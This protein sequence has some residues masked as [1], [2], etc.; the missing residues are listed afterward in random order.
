MGLNTE[1]ACQSFASRVSCRHPGVDLPGISIPVAVWPAI[2]GTLVHWGDRFGWDVI[3]QSIPLIRR[4]PQHPGCR[5]EREIDDVSQ[6]SGKLAP[7]AVNCVFPDGAPTGI[8]FDTHVAAGPEC[9]VEGPGRID[10]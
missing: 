8:G 2:V 3:A 10:R 5:I 6:P 1:V 9:D 7:G 4:R